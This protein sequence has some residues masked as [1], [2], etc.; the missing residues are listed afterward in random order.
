MKLCRVRGH[1][2]H[3]V[4]R[5]RDFVVVRE[6]AL[7]SLRRGNILIYR[8]DGGGYVVHRLIRKGKGGRLYLKGDGYGL[9]LEKA[10]EEA[11]LGKAIGFVRNGRYVPLGRSIELY[12]WFVSLFKEC[13]K[14]WIRDPLRL[15][16]H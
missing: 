15:W 7:T 1:S 13:A 3:P 11:L 5:D 10:G 9:P 16:G 8:E 2:M 12:S 4:L 14:R 6:A